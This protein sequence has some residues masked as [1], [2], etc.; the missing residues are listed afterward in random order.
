MTNKEIEHIVTNGK[1]PKDELDKFD[2]NFTF[3][4]GLILLFLGGV[5]RV[6]QG[7][8]NNHLE[9]SPIVHLIVATL[10]LYIGYSYKKN[11]KNLKLIPTNQNRKSN[12]E[13]LK[14]LSENEIYSLRFKNK[15]YFV[16]DYKGIF[17]QESHKLILIPSNDVIYMNLRNTGNITGRMPFLFGIDSRLESH[18]RDD[19]KNY[20]QQ[21]L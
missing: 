20:V 8:S 17:N 19:I 11:E 10:L 12:S 21:R 5:F 13:I 1:I 6:F 14:A 2:E 18:I 7:I 9:I 3:A 4:F 15:N 16:F